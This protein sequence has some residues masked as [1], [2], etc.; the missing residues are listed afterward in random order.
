MCPRRSSSRK[1]AMGRHANKRAERDTQTSAMLP[2]ELQNVEKEKV[3]GIYGTNVL[4][5]C[6]V[7]KIQKAQ[8]STKPWDI[9]KA[10]RDDREPKEPIMSQEELSAIV[11]RRLRRRPE[12]SG[13]IF[14]ET[15]VE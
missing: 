2:P 15:I 8:R 12:P 1:A 11:N 10:Q 14:F 4:P 13:S 7:E 6:E 5:A 3:Y 9:E